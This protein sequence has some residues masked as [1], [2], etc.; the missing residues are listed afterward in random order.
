MSAIPMKSII[1]IMQSQG[2]DRIIT[3]TGSGAFLQT[4]KPGLAGHLGHM[5]VKIF[6]SKILRDGEQHLGLLQASSLK[7]TSVRAP[8]M[9]NGHHPA[10][11][12]S[13][14]FPA[15]WST[16]PRQAVAH[17]LVDLAEGTEYQRQA[18]FIHRHGD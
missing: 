14:K 6:G 1:P 11:G 5:M 10:Y 12:L 18:P 7:W 15:L 3:V 16:I 4:D 8:A 13:L 9:T 2:L 17:C